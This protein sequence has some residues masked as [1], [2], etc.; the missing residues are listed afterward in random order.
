M[1]TAATDTRSAPRETPG[2]VD[3]AVAFTGAAR[4]RDRA[5]RV[6]GLTLCGVLLLAASASQLACNPGPAKTSLD[7][8]EDARRAYEG[9]MDEFRGHNWLESQALFREVKKNYAY[10]K[11]ARL[12]ELRIADADFEQDKFAEAVH[13]YRDFVQNHRADNEGVAYARSRIAEAQYK[14]V[15]ESFLSPTADERDQ[16]SVVDAYRELRG[17]LSD[18]PE[19]EASARSRKLLADI[20]AR[21]VRHELY[22]ARFYLAR[23]NYVATVGRV[24][25]ALR[26]YGGAAQIA[27]PVLVDSGLEPECLLLLGET[28]LRMH[29]W[30]DARDAFVSIL[31]DYPESP[32]TQPARNFLQYM[33]EHPSSAPPASMTSAA[34]SGRRVE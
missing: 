5:S 1:H 7:Y 2:C 11:Y 6:R 34:W 14:Q 10:S 8:T 23:N 22:V 31:R 28:F 21:L 32:L 12:A 25:Y 33:D 15:G 19:A 17:Y 20:T 29:Q 26:T 24:K 3:P 13:G 27:D 16:S 18:Y 30:T 9:A 4:S